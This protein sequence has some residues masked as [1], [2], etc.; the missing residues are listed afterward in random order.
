MLADGYRPLALFLAYRITG[1]IFPL[2]PG[3]AAVR[4]GIGEKFPGST[5]AVLMIVRNFSGNA[6]RL[7]WIGSPQ[8]LEI[9]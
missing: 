7:L 9:P 6:V 5:D 3:Q 4:Q 2:E 1:W 8:R